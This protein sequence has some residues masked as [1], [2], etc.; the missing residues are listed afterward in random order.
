M[1]DDA[2]MTA[3]IAAVTEGRSGNPVDARRTLLDLWNRIGSN[4]DALH[5][6]TLAHY[7]ADLYDDPAQSLAWDI[8]SLDAADALTDSRVRH[9]HATLYVAGFYPSLHLNLADDYRRL[10]SFEAAE[11]HIAAAKKLAKDLPDDSYG[12]G[13]RDAI[14]EIGQAIAGRD[15]RPRK[16]EEVSGSTQTD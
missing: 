9:H 11:D 4:G 3:I 10:S 16:Q 8:R 6:C 14:A 13:I 12:T 1:T 15:S 2:T 5:R 7:L